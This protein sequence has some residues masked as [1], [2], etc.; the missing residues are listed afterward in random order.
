MCARCKSKKAKCS[1]ATHGK[2]APGALTKTKGKGKAREKAKE[3]A[4]SVS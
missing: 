4:V 1:F 3:P 2:A